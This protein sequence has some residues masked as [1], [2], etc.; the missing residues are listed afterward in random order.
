[1]RERSDLTVGR[2]EVFGGDDGT[3]GAVRT[4]SAKLFLG[5][6]F[7]LSTGESLE[8]LLV[9]EGRGVLEGEHRDEHR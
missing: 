9:G 3:A 7:A 2:L 6:K 5:D 8:T 1:M 4:A